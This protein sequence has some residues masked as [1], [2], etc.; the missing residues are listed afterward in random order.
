MSQ[1]VTGGFLHNNNVEHKYWVI[2]YSMSHTSLPCVSMK[3]LS[4]ANELLT[5]SGNYGAHSLNENSYNEH[6]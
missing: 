1:I 2:C 4:K 5:I 6:I 3:Q